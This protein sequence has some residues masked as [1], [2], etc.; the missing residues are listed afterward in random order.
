MTK[1]QREVWD[2][3]KGL[4]QFG[5]NQAVTAAKTTNRKAVSSTLRITVSHGLVLKEGDS[6]IRARGA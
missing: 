5:F 1:A 4:R 3:I 2:K 6:Y